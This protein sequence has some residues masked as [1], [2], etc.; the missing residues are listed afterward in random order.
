MVTFAS[1][2]RAGFCTE[3]RAGDPDATPDGDDF[4]PRQV[5]SGHYV[6]VRPT[7]IE[8]PEY[9]AHSADLFREL[10]FADSLA[11]SVERLKNS[12]S[13]YS[14]STRGSGKELHEFLFGP[15]APA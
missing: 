11:R 15:Q 14:E 13:W 2:C 9:V 7:P 10:G 1:G 8:T 4:R 5:F 12:N 6:P 3:F